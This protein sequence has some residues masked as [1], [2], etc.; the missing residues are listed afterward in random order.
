MRLWIFPATIAILG[1][2][3]TEDDVDQIGCLLLGYE[4]TGSG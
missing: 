2:P 1:Y 3:R 4:G